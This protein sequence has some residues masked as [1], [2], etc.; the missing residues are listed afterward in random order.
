MAFDATKKNGANCMHS[1]VYW[2]KA[3]YMQAR[4]M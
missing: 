2:Q 4:R 3:M 1:S